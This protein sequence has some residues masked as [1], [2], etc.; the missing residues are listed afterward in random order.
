MDPEERREIGAHYTSEA[1]ILKVINPLFMD[2]YGQ[3]SSGLK[4]RQK[5]SRLSTK[6]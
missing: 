5:S 2:D 4:Q 6:R 3:N 1:N